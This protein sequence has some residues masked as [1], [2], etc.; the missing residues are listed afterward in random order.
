[1][2]LIRNKIF[3]LNHSIHA[4]SSVFSPA[5]DFTYGGMAHAEEGQFATDMMR[6][7]ATG[8]LPNASDVNLPLVYTVAEAFAAAASRRES[9]V[10]STAYHYN[11][12]RRN[13]SPARLKPSWP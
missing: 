2:H 8:S 7:V 12:D 3:A 1:V 6:K 13:S 4:E 9:Y 11:S 5:S 10:L